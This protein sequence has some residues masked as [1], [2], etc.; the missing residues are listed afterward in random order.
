MPTFGERSR[1]NLDTCHPDLQR[2]A[3]RAIK[4]FD[5]AVIEGHRNEQRQN[6]LFAQGPHVTK[7]KWP[8]SRH[9]SDPSEAFDLAP[10]PVEWKD[11]ERFA[12]LAGV[13]MAA[14]YEEGVEIRWGGDWDRD[15]KTT[16]EKFRDRPH[17]ELVRK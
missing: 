9:N 3:E 16:D 5:F 7:A 14:A 4:A 15:T 8:D 13:I 17:F 2:V 10:Y 6:E 1:R 12:Q 11:H